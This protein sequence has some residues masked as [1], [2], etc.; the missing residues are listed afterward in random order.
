MTHAQ[1]M[2]PVNSLAGKIRTYCKRHGIELPVCDSTVRR[3]M[4]K[5]MT[6]AQACS[7]PFTPPRKRGM[8]PSWKT[9]DIEA[10]GVVGT[11]GVWRREKRGMTYE[12]ALAFPAYCHKN[13]FAQVCRDHGIP[14]EQHSAYRK[15]YR[16]GVPIELVFSLPL[17]VGGPLDRAEAQANIRIIQREL[18]LS[19]G[20]ISIRQ[21]SLGWPVD[22]ALTAPKRSR[23]KPDGSYSNYRQEARDAGITSVEAY[24]RRRAKGWSQERASTTPILTGVRYPIPLTEIAAKHGIHR[25]MIRTGMQRFGLSAEE[26]AEAGLKVKSMCVGR[27]V[28]H[29]DWYKVMRRE[30]PQQ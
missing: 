16:R 5:G 24:C 29:W 3:R 21:G 22:V 14:Q 2:K 1:A 17:K 8:C 15:R 7:T 13:S 10:R 6:F 27:Q 28:T 26:A 4:G 23:K 12:E 19:N 30:A 20:A 11:S 25:C 9:R 18:G